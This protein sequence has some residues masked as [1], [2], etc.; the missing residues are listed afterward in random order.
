MVGVLWLCPPISGVTVCVHVHARYNSG[1]AAAQA[2]AWILKESRG[3]H[4]TGKKSIINSWVKSISSKTHPIVL[5]WTDCNYRSQAH[6]VFGAW[7]ILLGQMHF[8]HHVRRGGGEEKKVFW[9][10]YSWALFTHIPIY[11]VS[12]T[13]GWELRR[14]TL[15]R[16]SHPSPHP[17]DEFSLANTTILLLYTE[18]VSSKYILV[19]HF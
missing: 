18:E 13:W 10:M 1:Y 4:L 9:L 14:L 8:P 2:L 12:P 5:I 17:H 11:L 15:C 16:T 6:V 7:G 19:R 3:W